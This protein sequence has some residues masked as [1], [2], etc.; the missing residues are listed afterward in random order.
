MWIPVEFFYKFS[1]PDFKSTRK[2][3]R[4]QCEGRCRTK[5]KVWQYFFPWFLLVSFHVKKTSLS[6]NTECLA[7]FKWILCSAMSIFW[8]HIGQICILLILCSLSAIY[9]VYMCFEF[10]CWYRSRFK[11]CPMLSVQLFICL[12]SASSFINTCN[13]LLSQSLM[14]SAVS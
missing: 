3:R 13:F 5:Q 14:L 1:G 7:F 9:L 2:K 6:G 12:Y 8:S 10:D 11:I 4:K